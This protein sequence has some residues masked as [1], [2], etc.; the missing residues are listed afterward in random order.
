MKTVFLWV[1]L[2]TLAACSSP[3]WR[4]SS[5]RQLSQQDEF[6]CNH[7][8]GYYDPKVNPIV[9]GMCKSDCLQAKGFSTR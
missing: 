6:E 8:C 5:G 3:T 2:L 4:D 7:K 1:S 9:G